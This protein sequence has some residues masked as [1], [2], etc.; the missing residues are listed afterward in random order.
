MKQELSRRAFL[1]SAAAAAIG[2]SIAGPFHGFVAHAA[3]GARGRPGAGYGDLFPVADKRDGAM[4]LELPR[5]FQY[6]TFHHAGG[7]LGDGTV[8]P[9]FHD[10]MGALPG[11]RP[12]AT[13]LLRNH[14]VLGATG[15]F[16]PA[17]STYDPLT[18]GGVVA[19]E[20]DRHGNVVSDRVALS[21]TSI[22]CNGGL[23]PWGTWLSCE[24]TVNGDGI[25]PDFTGEDNT[26]RRPHGYV[27]EVPADGPSNATPI[28][29]AGRFWHE[30]AVVDPA[31]GYVYMTEDQLTAGFYRYRPPAGGDPTR[32]A[33][34]G[35]LE[36]L[37]V[38]GEPSADL[39]GHFPNGTSFRARWV[40]IA[41]PDPQIPPGTSNNDAALAVYNQGRAQGG[42]RFITLEGGTWS[43]GKVWFTSTAGGAPFPP[44]PVGRGQVW[45]YEPATETLT[46]VFE[47]PD[48]SALDLPDNIGVAPSGALILCEDTF[49]PCHVRG[50]TADGELFTFAR[51]I[52]QLAEFAGATFS[53]DGHTLFVNVLS[54]T[55]YSIAI[56]GPWAAGGFGR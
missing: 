13:L 37:A 2:A 23:T 38:E 12:G 16:G 5:G 21:G 49:T 42:A 17:A 31:T 10:G 26:G 39:S 14:E 6:R 11:S 7:A 18:G 40:P 35:T 48:P 32:L 15:A 47:T 50:L 56:W 36:M 19:V 54:A 53:P 9:G 43:A 22:N 44:I 27:F 41:E 4:R 51:N 46:M 20:V 24:E 45:S 52:D 8:I 29:S 33:D 28:R 3:P 30:A 55:G 34:G 1:G 25:G